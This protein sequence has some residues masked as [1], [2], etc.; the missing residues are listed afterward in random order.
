[1]QR[2]QEDAAPLG[3]WCNL[4]RCVHV[5]QALTAAHALGH[6][7]VA[8]HVAFNPYIEDPAEAAEERKRLNMKLQTGLVAGVY[9]QTGSALDRL[10]D[11]L[12]HLQRCIQQH[13][14]KHAALEVAVYGSVFMPTKR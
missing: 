4:S 13:K 5:L 10:E 1:M 7:P 14:A 12:V 6:A 8:I 2:F 11:G 3:C 9:L